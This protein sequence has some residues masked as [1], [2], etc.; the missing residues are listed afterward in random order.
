MLMT[1]ANKS[2]EKKLS[3][4]RT[5]NYLEKKTQEARVV[6]A[7]LRAT[8]TRLSCSP[9]FPRASYLDERTLTYEPI[10]SANP[11]FAESRHSAK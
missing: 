6:S 11:S 1:S 10:V 3:K 2:L 7:T 5:K 4:K 8:L 9:N